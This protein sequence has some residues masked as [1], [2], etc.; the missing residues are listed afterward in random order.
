MR[1]VQNTPLPKYLAH[2]QGIVNDNVALTRKKVALSRV[3]FSQVPLSCGKNIYIK[4][5]LKSCSAVR[6]SPPAPIWCFIRGLARNI[7]T[8]RPQTV[9]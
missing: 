8:L 5:K 6:A 2:A 9:N 1:P 3:E 4:Q 7:I